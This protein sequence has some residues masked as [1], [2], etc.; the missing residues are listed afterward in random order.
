MLGV[1]CNLFFV[2]ALD[3]IA[4]PKTTQK[5]KGKKHNYTLCNVIAQKEK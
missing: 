2:C 4:T 5:K 1:Q 3:R